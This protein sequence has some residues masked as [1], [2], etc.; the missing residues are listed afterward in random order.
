[1][2][3]PWSCKVNAECPANC[4]LYFQH[5]YIIHLLSEWNATN[6]SIEINQ[7]HWTFSLLALGK[8]NNV[9][10]WWKKSPRPKHAWQEISICNT[11]TR[12]KSPSI[13]Q[14]YIQIGIGKLH[15]TRRIHWRSQSS[16]ILAFTTLLAPSR[17]SIL[18][19]HKILPWKLETVSNQ[20]KMLHNSRSPGSQILVVTHLPRVDTSSVY[21]IYSDVTVSPMLC[22]KE[23]F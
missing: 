19:T 8:S 3:C 4:P 7:D 13:T 22:R 17:W 9:D 21:T 15:P 14:M 12:F 20:R 16:A 10:R 11:D 6:P 5:F 2:F 18:K 1:M 23:I